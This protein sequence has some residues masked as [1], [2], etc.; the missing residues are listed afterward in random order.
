MLLHGSSALTHAESILTPG[1]WCDWRHVDGRR[2]NSARC[3]TPASAIRWAR[4]QIRIVASAVAP[5]SVDPLVDRTYQ[6]WRERP[7]LYR[8]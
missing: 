1:F 4:V 6:G 5:D 7:Y 8:S 2:I 3:P